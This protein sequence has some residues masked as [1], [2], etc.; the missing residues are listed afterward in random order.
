MF[1][2]MPVILLAVIFGIAFLD[3][4]IPLSVKSVLYALSLSIKSVIIFVL[5]MIIFMLLFKTLAQLTGRATT[6]LLTILG[7]VC[8]SNFISTMMSYIVGS[9]IY[10]FDLSITVPQ[11][12]AGLQPAW[13]YQMP[14]FIPNSWAMFSGMIS[15]ALFS[16]LRP[17]LAR[18]I[19]DRFEIVVSTLLRGILY[20]IP[21]FLAGF[22]VKIIHDEVLDNI[23]RDYAW[24]FAVVAF[25]QLSYVFILY[26]FS[27]N[28]KWTSS[29]QAIKNMLPA[30]IAGFGSMSSA[31][32]MPLTIVGSEKNVQDPALIRLAIPTTVNIHLIGD[33]FA[34]PIFA[35]A[36]LKNFGVSE[37][38]FASYLLFAC[39][40]VMAKFSVAA[41]PG[42]GVLV[43]LPILESQLGFTGEMSSLVTALY[44]LFDPVITATNVLGNGAFALILNRLKLKALVSNCINN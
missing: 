42:G 14:S 39:Y 11:D 27:Q 26:A 19:A 17:V 28:F 25:A 4:W 10:Q 36:I 32:A 3:S 34:I 13:I 18:K 9:T 7:A 43:M 15:G 41:I 8:L 29:I 1:R 16:F 6:L 20:L 40:F 24:I 5:P 38:D 37:P 12:S 31:A 23:V 22:I 35:F 33:C 2:K 44:I 21:F 30:A